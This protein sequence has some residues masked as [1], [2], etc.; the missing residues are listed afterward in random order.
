M[1]KFEL[2]SYNKYC[3]IYEMLE[4]LLQVIGTIVSYL[5]KNDS[6]PSILI[7]DDN[8]QSSDNQVCLIKAIIEFF[9]ICFGVIVYKYKT[10]LAT[11]FCWF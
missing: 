2:R 1:H 10:F 5:N 9:K 3:S 4:K 6:Y 8:I 11:K 7:F